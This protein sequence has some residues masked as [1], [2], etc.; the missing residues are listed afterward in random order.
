[1]IAAVLI[2]QSLFGGL[3]WAQ[4]TGSEVVEEQLQDVQELEK[5]TTG[6]TLTPD[7]VAHLKKLGV[8]VQPLFDVQREIAKLA[9]RIGEA[10]MQL[11]NH[12]QENGSEQAAQQIERQMRPFDQLYERMFAFEVENRQLRKQ[13]QVAMREKDRAKVQALYAE[14]LSNKRQVQALMQQAYA[15]L[16][17]VL[18]QAGGETELK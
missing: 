8:A 2:S 15:I 3:A 11:Y 14:F 18:A 10:A 13:I 4:E 7:Q 6:R 5:L 16:R 17:D 1:M 12:L 9:D